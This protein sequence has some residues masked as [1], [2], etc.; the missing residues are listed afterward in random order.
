MQQIQSLV[1]TAKLS[2]LKSIR[3]PRWFFFLAES[4]TKSWF[5]LETCSKIHRFMASWSYSWLVRSGP[6][7]DFIQ[8][9]LGLFKLTNHLTAS[10]SGNAKYQAVSM[11][12]WIQWDARSLAILIYIS[13][14]CNVGCYLSCI[15]YTVYIYSIY[16]VYIYIYSIYTVNKYQ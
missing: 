11:C 10:R 12:N 1:E 3:E 9:L 8:D 15:Q 16:G 13:F 14:M 7:M 4:D 6:A 5:W 2:P